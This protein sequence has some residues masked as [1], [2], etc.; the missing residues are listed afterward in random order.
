MASESMGEG[1]V[2]QA[3]VLGEVVPAGFQQAQ[4]PSEA[5]LAAPGAAVPLDPVARNPAFRHGDWWIGLRS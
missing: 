3:L 5:I 1:P 2:T 4:A